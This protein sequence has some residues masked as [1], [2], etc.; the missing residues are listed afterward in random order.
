MS[1]LASF[2]FGDLLTL[3]VDVYY[4]IYFA[5]IAG[6][7]ALYARKTNL[8]LADWTSPRLVRGII[9]GFA[10][11]I[12]ML[13]NVLSRPATE[14]LTGG[15]LAWAV[16][17]RGFVYGGV[18]GLLLFAFP[19]IVTWRAFNAESGG[20]RRKLGAGFFSWLM[21]VFVTTV[22]HLGYSDFR[23]EKII[24]PNIGS[25]IMAVPTLVTA[26]AVASPI[27]HVIMH[28]A[29]VIHSPRTALFLPPH[30]DQAAPS[31]RPERQGAR[32]APRA[33]WRAAAMAETISSDL[34]LEL[35][36]G[37]PNVSVDGLGSSVQSREP[38]S[39]FRLWNPPGPDESHDVHAP[40]RHAADPGE[41]S[42]RE[43]LEKG[44]R[45]EGGA[46]SSQQREQAGGNSY[47]QRPGAVLVGQPM[48]AVREHDTHRHR[49]DEQCEPAHEDDG[50]QVHAVSR[51]E[52]HQP[53]PGDQEPMR[54]PD[55]PGEC[56][57]DGREL[58]RLDRSENQQRR[59]P[60]THERHP[61]SAV[62][63]LQHE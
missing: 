35:E 27:S 32:S 42:Y 11:G 2:L 51:R 43:V 61:C 46:Q 50:Q 45:S 6:F 1:F 3:P 16:F 54:R 14:R 29:A 5:A 19:W 8:D 17:W 18:D 57:T 10:V 49:K 55:A 25:T 53:Q 15:L 33:I 31:E 26:N 20:F 4:L 7:F 30:R 58:P 62:A 63:I 41:R 22:Y 23:S 34:R 37:P 21:I 40:E 12:V 48:A 9:L 39:A 38:A 52:R 44:F 60:G 36:Q 47:S 24:Q 59:H 13:M 56:A 28:V